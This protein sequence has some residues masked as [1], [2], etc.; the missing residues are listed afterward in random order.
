MNLYLVKYRVINKEINRGTVYVM[1][2]NADTLIS[3]INLAH[4]SREEKIEVLTIEDAT[5]R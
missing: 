1:W 2:V 5:D 3:A 4:N